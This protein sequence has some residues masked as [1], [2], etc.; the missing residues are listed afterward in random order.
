VLLGPAGSVI[1][2]AVRVRPDPAGTAPER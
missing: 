1:V 2:V